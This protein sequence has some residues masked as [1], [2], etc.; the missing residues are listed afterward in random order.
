MPFCDQCGVENPDWARFCDQC[1]APLTPVQQQPPAAASA[2]APAAA[3]A[4]AV[5][6][7][8]CG[9]PVIAGEAFCNNCGTPLLPPGAPSAPAASVPPQPHYPA[10]QPLS[11]PPSSPPS[12]APAATQSSLAAVQLSIPAR[13]VR[14]SMPAA[15]SVLIGRSDAVS[16]F[17]PD[18][19]LTP[20][21]G[22]EQGVGRRHARLFIRHN[23][24]Y[25][26][27]QDST[28]GTFLNGARLAPHTPQ[29]I[30]SGDEVRLGMLALRCEW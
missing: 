7:P 20:Y 18:I 27:D 24:L 1:G 11:P 28:N 30:G 9:E 25:I 3:P 17:Y 21:G 5:S 16:G 8:S 14:L 19:D 15:E 4:A 23:T 12:P 29:P 6:C 10:P 2:S 13:N 26:E 22:I